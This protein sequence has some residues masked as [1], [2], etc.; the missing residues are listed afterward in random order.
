MRDTSLMAYSELDITKRQR[1]VWNYLKLCGPITGRA[2]SKSIPGA[3]KRL[4]EL[5]I[6]G[7]AENCGTTK[8]PITDKIVRLW[9]ATD[10]RTFKIDLTQPK[11]KSRKELEEENKYLLEQ[12]S[13]AEYRMSRAYDSGYWQ[14]KRE[15]GADTEEIVDRMGA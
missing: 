14:A 8:D 13:K 3:W 9:R 12:L 1:E 10:Q 15:D 4:N 5:K 2:L 7:F 11:R 6:M